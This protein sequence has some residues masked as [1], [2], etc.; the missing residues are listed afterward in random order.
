[1]RNKY[2]VLLLLIVVLLVV[3]ITCGYS[4]SL[5]SVSHTQETSNVVNT[6][7]FE[8]T[9]SEAGSNI[10]LTNTYPI[11]DTKGLVTTPYTFTITNTCSIASNASIMINPQ[12][13]T[14][15]SLD[16]IKAGIKETSESNY[17]YK[18]LKSSTEGTIASGDTTSMSSYILTTAYLK[19]NA[20][21]T[22]SIIM[23]LGEDAGNDTQGKTLQASIKVSDTATKTLTYS[24]TT[25]ASQPELYQGMIPVKYDATGNIVVADTTQEWYDY[26]NHDW[27][28]AVLVNCS[29]TTIKDKYFNS[30]M[31][32]KSS[33]VGTTISM[34][35]ILQMYVWIPRYKYLL[36]NAENGSSDPQAITIV[37]ESKDTAKSTGSTN[38]TYLTHP[39]FTFGTTEL[40]GIWVGKFENSGTTSSIQIKPNQ[41]SLTNITV[42]DMFNATR[43]E[44]LT[45]A[46]NYG[47]DN[48]KVD[49]HM[50]KNMEWGAVAYLSSSI[51]GRYKDA[52]TCINTGCEVWINN[53]S[54]FIT[55]C[56]GA[57]A[58]A[59]RDTTNTTACA[60]GYDW[61]TLGVNASTT[62]NQYGIY[63]MS[64]GAFEYVM[65]NMVDSSG[66]FQPSSSGLS[67]PDTKYY[68]SYA[69]DASSFTTHARGKLDDA[70]KETLKIFG[71]NT[72]GWYSDGSEFPYISSSW[73]LRGGGYSNFT[74]AGVFN[75][76]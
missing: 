20:T 40:N 53:V 5:W 36:W 6:G 25:G 32:L 57:S 2:K 48:T 1:M 30:D 72:G 75:F 47:I 39:A 16:Y 55:G 68:D 64:G 4:Y 58:S 18:L 23:W 43:N 34:S 14:T 38:G 33:T 45:Y 49:T 70:T 65:G 54:G 61:T 7:C 71:S 60:S 62:G 63:D 66:N 76:N 8:V 15:L 27:A 3:T 9:F 12:T 31:T 24:D 28:N 26:A 52:S 67:Q 56:S 74:N 22:Y 44:E 10:N 41:Q 50:M 51:Y 69:Y 29:D 21:K 17:T 11:S 35:D 59:S 37:F 46:T 13:G 19:P 73:F 42:G